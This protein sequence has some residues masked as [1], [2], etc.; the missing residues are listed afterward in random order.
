MNTAETFTPLVRTTF[1]NQRNTTHFLKSK[2]RQGSF[3]DMTCK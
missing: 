1:T 2:R 3:T